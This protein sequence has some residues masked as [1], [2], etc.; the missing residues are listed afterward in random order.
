MRQ[1]V[2][3]QQESRTPDTAGGASLSWV[4]VATLWAEVTPFPGSEA[5]QAQKL[6]GSA[7]Y[8]VVLRYKD[9]VTADMRLV[10][11]GR[12]LNIRSLRNVGERDRRLEIMA[13]EG[14]AV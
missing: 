8:R 5:L 2:T 12:V 11:K 1:R 3:L 13:E 4:D 10:F 14:V 7:L 6:T 9:A